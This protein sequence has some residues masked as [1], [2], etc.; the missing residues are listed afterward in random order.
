MTGFL[1][2]QMRG[3]LVRLG[4]AAG[5]LAGAMSMTSVANAGEL[6]SL[7][8]R[9][10]ETQ[11]IFIEQASATPQWVVLLFA[12]GDGAVGLDNQGPTALQGNFLLRTRS[13]WVS[14]NDAIA[15]VDAPSDQSNGMNDA[16]RL[17]EAHAADMHAVTAFLRQRY[18]SAKIALVG[19]SRGTISVGNVLNREP[20]LADAYVLTSPVTIGMGGQ[21]GLSGMHWEIGDT[22]VLVVSNEHDGCKVSPFDAARTLATDNKLQFIAVS[23]ATGGGRAAECGARSPHGFLGIENGVL[24]AISRWLGDRSSV[25][26][27]SH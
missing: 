5:C 1:M 7:P 25:S 21:A 6:V 2:Q 16:F 19:T 13:Y 3:R 26:P 11:R 14:S 9:G 15:I 18:P 23:S 4:M 8:V 20:A 17:S 27:A 10:Q 22:P 12:G 24:D